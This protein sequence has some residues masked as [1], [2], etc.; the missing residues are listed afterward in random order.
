MAQLSF[1]SIV[2][3]KEKNPLFKERASLDATLMGA[4]NKYKSRDLEM[5]ST[6]KI[7]SKQKKRNK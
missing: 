4:P 5:S 1:L 6:K 2:L 7:S 3:N